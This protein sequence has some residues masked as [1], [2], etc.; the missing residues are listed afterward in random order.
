[1]TFSYRPSQDSI[2][3]RNIDSKLNYNEDRILI[4][5][6]CASFYWDWYALFF[7]CLW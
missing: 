5:V 3:E 4:F 2:D 7:N 1:M 6:H